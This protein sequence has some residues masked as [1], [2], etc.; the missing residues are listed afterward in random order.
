[1]TC[2]AAIVRELFNLPS[3][4]S[5]GV[6]H[7][8]SGGSKMKL[9]FGAALGWTLAVLIASFGATGA[10]ASSGSGT[11]SGSGPE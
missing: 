9:K 7:Q 10:G 8:N 4:S 2:K 5:R 11:R 6:R 3:L 1:M